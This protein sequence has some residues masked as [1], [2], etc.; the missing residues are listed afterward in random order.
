MTFADGV[1]DVGE[2]A[3]QPGTMTEIRHIPLLPGV[4][5]LKQRQRRAARA[6]EDELGSSLLA[7]RV[8]VSST[9]TRQ[10]SVFRTAQP[11]DDGVPIGNGKALQSGQIINQCLVNDP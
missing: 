1:Y 9:S 10:T 4:G 11:G 8:L 2:V 3:A 7:D 6:D 5:F